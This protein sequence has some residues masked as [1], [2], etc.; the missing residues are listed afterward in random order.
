MT[1]QRRLHSG[2]AALSGLLVLALLLAFDGA[3]GAQPGDVFSERC[4]DRGNGKGVGPPCPDALSLRIHKGE[5]VEFGTLD[6]DGGPY[7]RNKATRLRL[8]TDA[9]WDLR[10]STRVTVA[11]A[12]ASSEAVLEALSVDP[13]AESGEGKELNLK[14]GYALAGLSGL[15]GGFYELAVTFRAATD[16]AEARVTAKLYFDLNETLSLEIADGAVVSFGTLD[17]AR[18]PY[19]RANA[20]RLRVAG[21][22]AWRLEANK[23]VVTQPEGANR[24]AVLDALIVTL[25]HARG[26]GAGT[27][28]VDYRLDDLEGLPDGN[29]RYDVVFTVTAR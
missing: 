1:S 19:V 10:V 8:E 6:P 2:K 23:A 5:V 20:T 29:Y 17:P 26:E 14:V 27:V 11:P 4:G 21:N 18:G 13:E 24:E 15:P 25:T 7:A 3:Y 22:A 12:G 16:E 9:H 28:A